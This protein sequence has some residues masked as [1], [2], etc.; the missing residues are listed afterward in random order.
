MTTVTE[1]TLPQSLDAER[2]VL[3]GVLLDN[4]QLADA[5]EQIDAT[6]FFRD[7]HRRIFSAMLDLA[8]RREVIDLLTLKD[9]LGAQSLDAVG[10]PTYIAGLIDGV[11]RSTN[12][13][14]YAR[15]VRR[16][17]SL[18]ALIFAANRVLSRAYDDADDA[19][20]I[21]E[22]AE[23][24]IL[25]LAD[26][27]TVGGFESMQSIAPRAF[28]L[29]EKLHASKSGI[30]GVAS[31]FI[32]LDHLTRGFQPGTLVVLGA[33][34]GIGKSSFAVNIAQNAGLAGHA[35]GVFSLEMPT[36]ELFFR[37]IASTA[38]IDSHR[39]QSGY[40]GERDWARVAEAMETITRM[41]LYLDET[42]AIGLYAVRSRARRLKAE[43]GLDLLVIDY[44][45]L[46]ATSAEQETRAQAIGAITAAL[47]ALAKE[48]RIPVL[49]LSQLSREP[50]KRGSRPKLSDLRDSGSIEQ[51]ADIVL[52]LHRDEQA[53]HTELILAKHRNGPVG[54]V[55]LRWTEQ[56]T[57][58]NTYGAV[59]DIPI[60][61]R[62]P[63]GDR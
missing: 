31:G 2:A 20:E 61:T 53:D 35:V 4:S 6:Q 47:K 19:S 25:G 27:V 12:V 16:T 21:L 18:R 11:P 43:H 28:A 22:E 32:D 26:N 3:G 33:R 8:E 45:Q 24:V 17:A 52:F 10:G 34:P 38:R 60:E 50:E 5:C 37:Q 63:M 62:L 49:V 1:R 40:L 41:P 7:A 44:L 58:F 39:L 14:H 56:Q 36:E 51:D 54:T 46:M 9:E 57:R 13:A 42:P 48:M 55:K 30:T 15:I 23:R 29:L 59:E